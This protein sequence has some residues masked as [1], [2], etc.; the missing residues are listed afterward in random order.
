MW[1]LFMNFLY[2]KYP[3]WSHRCGTMCYSSSYVW[4]W[5]SADC[6]PRTSETPLFFISFFSLT[7]SFLSKITN[8]PSSVFLRKTFERFF[9]EAG[10]A[11][12]GS[13][14]SERFGQRWY[15]QSSDR[16]RLRFILPVEAPQWCCSEWHNGITL[17]P[18]WQCTCGRRLYS[19]STVKQVV[20]IRV[21]DLQSSF[22]WCD[23]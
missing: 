15:P 22:P 10:W 1:E 8:G 9:S 11:F 2:C 3:F 14:Q 18:Y 5:I 21:C 20:V 23:H 13:K 4:Q 6:F 7:I 16:W 12:S 19:Q 17:F